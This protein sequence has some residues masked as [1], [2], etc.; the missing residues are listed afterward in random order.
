MTEAWTRTTL[1]EVADIISGATPSTSVKDYW[2]GDI[3][4]ATPKDLSGLE[5]SEISETARKITRAGL[6]SC[7]ATVLPPYSVLLSSRA[8]I[9]LVAVNTAPMATN[10]GFKSLVPDRRR[11]DPKFLYWWL[12]E[13]RPLLESLGNGATFKEL[14]KKTTASVPMLLPSIGDQ[15][16]IAAILD[17]AQALRARRRHAL[18]TLDS[19]AQ[20]VFVK[21]F[22]HPAVPSNGSG[23]SCLG[24]LVELYSGSTLPPGEPYVGQSG[25]YMLV[26]VSDLSNPCND[27]Y[28]TVSQQWSASRGP[29]ASTCPA[30]SVVIPKRGG[31]IGTNRKRIA[32]RPSILDPNLMALT[33]LKGAVEV[34]YLY[35][36][37]SFLDLSTI[38]SGSSIPQINKKDLA[39]LEFPIAR[40]E[41]QRRYSDVVFRIGAERRRM[42]NAV[43]L[44]DQILMALQHRAFRGEL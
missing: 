41:D 18:A 34:E 20:A 3:C 17:A 16:R 38:Q 40:L 9:G 25:G 7:A 22:G 30:G 29:A 6:R 31:A 12:R 4:W 21:M 37:L 5:G 36:W 28:L 13:N 32:S 14:S 27:K 23:R 35:G 26:K 2:D 1:G 44:C 8:P 19:L 42:A 24:D 43:D 33:P 15:R 11:I 39:P 10:Q